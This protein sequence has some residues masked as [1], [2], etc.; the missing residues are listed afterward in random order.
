MP[1]GQEITLSCTL[2]Y[3]QQGTSCLVRGYCLSLF[4]PLLTWT[5]GDRFVRC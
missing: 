1:S 3:S 5:R 4:S 2:G